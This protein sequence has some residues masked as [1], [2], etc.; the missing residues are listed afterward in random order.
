MTD[1]FFGIVMG[2]LLDIG[3][4]PAGQRAR[5]NNESHTR[6]AQGVGPGVGR[7]GEGTGNYAY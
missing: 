2:H 5:Q 3:N 7:S 4:G 1:D 6:H